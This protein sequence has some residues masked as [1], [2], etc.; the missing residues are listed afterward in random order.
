M[1]GPIDGDRWADARVRLA[2]GEWRQ[3]FDVEIKAGLRP[4]ALGIIAHRLA[5]QKGRALLVADHVT[6][7]MADTLRAQGIQFLDTAGNGYLEQ[8][9]VFV[10]VKGER[11]EHTF[12]NPRGRGRAFAPTGLRVLLTLLCKPELVN[13]PYREIAIA[14]GVA[15]GTVGWVMPELEPLG[16]IATLAG[17]RRLVNAGELLKRWTE[18]YL[19]ALRPRLVLGRYHADNLAWWNTVA[20]LTY[21]YTLGGEA[22]AGRITKKNSRWLAG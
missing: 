3:D 18:A 21:G 17:K 20:P 4:A 5:P 7:P 14:A 15:H 11:P 2:L 16:F 19:R 6:P 1:R 10:W 22:A 12:R 8:P 13:R 9:E